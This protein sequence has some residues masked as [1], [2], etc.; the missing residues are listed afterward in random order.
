M[1]RVKYLCNACNYE[2]SRKADVSFF[3]CP[4]CGKDN[5][6]EPKKDNYASKLLDEVSGR[7]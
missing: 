1:E 3:K 5:T 2:F 6:V 7:E 4:Y